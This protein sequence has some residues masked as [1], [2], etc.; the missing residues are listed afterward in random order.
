MHADEGGYWGFVPES[1]TG[2][3]KS[4]Q[5]GSRGS[6]RSRG[7]L[8]CAVKGGFYLESYLSQRITRGNKSYEDCVRFFVRRI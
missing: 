7:I 4:W 3:G 1:Q 6:A 8:C 5:A 2:N